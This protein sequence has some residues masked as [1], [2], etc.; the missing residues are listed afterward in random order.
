MQNKRLY[1]PDYHNLIV[2]Q[3]AMDL[4]DLIKLLKVKLP[5]KE[6]QRLWKLVTSI[7]VRIAYGNSQFYENQKDYSL[8]MALNS[9]RKVNELLLSISNER[10]I[11][12]RI[13]Q[14][15]TGIT[16]EICKILSRMIN[17]ETK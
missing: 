5:S 4:V 13:F 8:K 16:I 12:Q 9:A 15:L 7:P 11:D 10:A 3:K 2:Y 14:D 17:R 6:E 1:L